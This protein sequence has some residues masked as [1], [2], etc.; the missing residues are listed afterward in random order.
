MTAAKQVRAQYTQEFKLDRIDALFAGEPASRIGVKAMDSS[1]VMTMLGYEAKPVLLAEGKV[2]QGMENHPE[3]TAEVWK[4]VPE[5]LD[6][7]AAV[8]DSDTDGG[9]V[10][11][12]PETVAGKAVSVIVRPDGER[13]NALNVHLLLNAYTRSIST[14]YQR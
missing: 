7:P 9:L 13:R 10:V 6:N 3:M 5:W 14:P 1:D 4:K 8:F 2:I 12:A 11:I